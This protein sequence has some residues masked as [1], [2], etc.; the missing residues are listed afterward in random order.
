M[1]AAQGVV[2]P[3]T[4][5]LGGD[6]F[7][8]VHCDGDPVPHALNASG[9]SGSGGE[10][11]VLRGLGHTTFPRD[12]PL[13]VTI[14]G[15]VDGLI[16][17]SE[18]FGNTALAKV[19]EPAETLAR[20]GFAVSTE[21]SSAFTRLAG[22]YR[23]NPAVSSF[24]PGGEPVSVGDIVQRLDLA[25]TLSD[26]GKGG[27]NA[28]YRGIPGEDIVAALDGFITPDDLEQGMADWVDPISVNIGDDTAWV[29]PPNSAGY[30]GPATLSVFLRLDPPND[31]SDPLWWHLMIEAHRSLAWERE[32]LVS[33]PETVEVAAELLLSDERLDMAAASISRDHA[34]T[35][36][37]K[38]ALPTGTAYMCV[39]A[40]DLSVSIINSNY[41][42][43]GSSF[44]AAHSGF[45]LQDRGAGFSVEAGHPNEL[46]PGKRPAHTLAPTLWTRGTA[47]SWVLGTRGGQIQP[48]LVA[49]LAARAITGGEPLQAAQAAPRWSMTE[50]GPGSTSA[51]S[52]EPGTGVARALEGLGHAVS[53]KDSR[54]PGWGPMS[55]IDKRTGSVKAAA[56][57]RVDTTRAL[58][59]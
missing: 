43:T 52:L 6:L 3:E 4:C 53:E 28:F 54:Q 24:Y 10:P 35:W 44:G 9:R 45:L 16:A 34:G 23:E 47:T 5:G 20:E 31:P 25:R 41:W 7:A 58:V 32:R 56:D 21:Q 29:I 30:L 57:P 12:H 50:Y 33:D 15:C 19:L 14:P 1:V 18:R 22:V 42:G 11:S 46:K 2:A 26:L 37:T 8:I 27:R 40:A 48:Q 13:A 38:P 59:F 51:V 39:A 49:Q 17:L 55:I 36:P